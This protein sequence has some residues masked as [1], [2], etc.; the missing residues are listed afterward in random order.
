MDLKPGPDRT[1]VA[2]GPKVF[3]IFQ[4]AGVRIVLTLR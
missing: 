2:K 3:E 1:F 4:S